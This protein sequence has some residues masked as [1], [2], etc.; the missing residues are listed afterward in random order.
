MTDLKLVTWFLLLDATDEFQR[1]GGVLP[2]VLF[3][4]DTADEVLFFVDGD[5]AF[6]GG[7][8]QTVNALNL[9]G[10]LLAVRGRLVAAL[11]Q[12]HTV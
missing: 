3:G 8:F 4:F 5:F 10:G 12:L 7:V 1:K 9:V 6:L 11:F 2:A